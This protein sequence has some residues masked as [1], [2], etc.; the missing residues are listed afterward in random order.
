M[1]VFK[2]LV[3]AQNIELQGEFIAVGGNSRQI[4]VLDKVDDLTLLNTTLTYP[5]NSSSIVQQGVFSPDG[6]WLAVGASNSSTVG[7]ASMFMFKRTIDGLSF[8]FHSTLTYSPEAA[9][10]YFVRSIDWHPTEDI[11]LFGLSATGTATANTAGSISYLAVFKLVG[12]VFVSTTDNLLF[13]FSGRSA[14]FSQDG[15]SIVAA[16]RGFKFD[17]VT[18]AILSDEFNHYASQ[19]FSYIREVDAKTAFTAD[20]QDF[21]NYFASVV[22]LDIGTPT[23]NT[24]SFA[25]ERATIS[26][27]SN[28]LFEASNGTYRLAKKIGNIYTLLNAAGFPLTHTGVLTPSYSDC[29]TADERYLMATS[30]TLVGD[31]RSRYFKILPDDTVQELSFPEPVKSLNASFFAQFPSNK[32]RPEVPVDRRRPNFLY[33]G[34]T[35]TSSVIRTY[36]VTENFVYPRLDAE[37]L[38]SPGASANIIFEL[39]KT[40]AACAYLYGLT[41]FS[42][43]TVRFYKRDINFTDEFRFTELNS[44]TLN[45]TGTVTYDVAISLDGVYVA[46]SNGGTGAVP[47]EIYKREGDL[48][49]KLAA[50]TGTLTGNNQTMFWSADGLY[51]YTMYGTNFQVIG[52]SGDSFSVIQTGTIGASSVFFALRPVTRNFVVTDDG[53]VLALN[54]NTITDL[55]VK[56]NILPSVGTQTRRRN[57]NMICW[58]PDGNFVVFHGESGLAVYEFNPVNQALTQVFTLTD[59]LIGNSTGYF[60]PNNKKFLIASGATAS[61]NT[62]DWDSITKEMAN[63]K[64]YPYTLTGCEANYFYPSGEYGVVPD[65]VTQ[66]VVIGTQQA[67]YFK[68]YSIDAAALGYIG[69]P[70]IPPNG[71]IARLKFSSNGNKLI[72][73][74]AGEKIYSYTRTAGAYAKDAISLS[75]ALSQEVS[76]F[77]MNSS[78][79]KLYVG[80]K[81]APYLKTY[82]RLGDVYTEDDPIPEAE[83][84][85]GEVTSVVRS[86]TGNYLA[87]AHKNFP[88]LTVYPLNEDELN[89]PINIGSLPLGDATCVAFSNDDT[90]MLVG[91]QGSNRINIYKAS[92]VNYIRLANADVAPNF[93]PISICFDGAGTTVIVGGSSSPFLERYSR[94]GDA[95]AKQAV[96]TQLPTGAVL[97]VS[98][99]LDDK[100]LFATTVVTPFIASYL[101]TTSG[102]SKL[103]D[104]AELPDSPAT[105]I[106]FYKEAL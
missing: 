28:Y 61:C 25:S 46:F 88:Y 12:D 9:N 105:T 15:N 50:V 57:N 78:G 59:T 35:T 21:R 93:D 56:T 18:G 52:R 85:T 64:T 44:P 69:E 72:G 4:H 103:P 95:F 19:A 55:G 74:G 54:G 14:Y 49:T 17:K 98:F 75:T 5:A 70:A 22:G 38:P 53:R 29:I 30:A 24:T 3:G 31:A 20:T 37:R 42:N 87:V 41:T 11:V 13:E 65:D 63:K 99:D 104:P 10:R 101:R 58:S 23:K 8:E 7:H 40:D 32:V 27:N 26:K 33:F 68:S 45:L 47:L 82:T 81:T 16:A 43:R 90:Y 1:D 80:L 102:Y 62:L 51:L 34:S 71:A 60:L 96:F 36:E 91:F 84:P 94:A 89:A 2:L 48:L 67:P 86:N 39:V 66:Y 97:S 83:R 106:T 79:D 76:T 92:G 77:D 73:V 100:I 6:Q